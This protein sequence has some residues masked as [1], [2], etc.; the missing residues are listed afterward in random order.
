MAL[1]RLRA[2]SQRCSKS[3]PVAVEDGFSVSI[4]CV[5]VVKKSRS[6]DIEN[7]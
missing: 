1:R 4:E 6:Q 5:R 3:P 2:L 7:D